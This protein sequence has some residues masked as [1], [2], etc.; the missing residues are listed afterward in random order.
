MY[1]VNAKELKSVINL[2]IHKRVEYFK[3]K[4]A[5]WEKL[6]LMEDEN[7]F[8][9]DSDSNGNE[10]LILWPFKAFAEFS[11]KNHEKFLSQL[12]KVDIHYFLN[13]YLEY[14]KEHNIKLLIF[15]GLNNDGAL[16][17]AENFKNMM[18][19]ELDKYGDYDEIN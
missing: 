9:T 3:H 1:N 12:K 18:M 7:G 8:F 19:E 16:F 15:P 4:V 14:I 10:I 5:D 13:H 2:D 6:W 11:L 17:D